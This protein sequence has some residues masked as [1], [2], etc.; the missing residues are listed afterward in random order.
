MA[1]KELR[2]ALAGGGAQLLAVSGDL[3]TG[4]G[5][6]GPAMAIKRAGAGPAEGSD[7]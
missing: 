6:L 3:Q 7:G 5:E 4:C 1:G 2:A